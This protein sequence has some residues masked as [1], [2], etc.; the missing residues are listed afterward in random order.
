MSRS[1]KNPYSKV[2]ITVES[3]DHI[4]TYLI[5]QAKGFR[6]ERF[7]IPRRDSMDLLFVKDL[8]DVVIKFRAARG[9]VNENY[10]VETI[11]KK[12]GNEI[13]T[14]TFYPATGES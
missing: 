2:T 6:L 11:K 7:S 10:I 8:I 1:K 9:K 14:C 12:E 3:E 5:P 13:E 4:T